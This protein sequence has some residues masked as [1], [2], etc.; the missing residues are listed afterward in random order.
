MPQPASKVIV[1][2]KVGHYIVKEL[3]GKGGMA[4]VYKAYDATLDREIALKVMLPFLTDDFEFEQRFLREARNAAKLDHP[5]I[6]GVYAADRFQSMLYIAMQFVN[7]RSLQKVIFNSKVSVDKA[8]LITFQMAVALESAHNKGIIHRDIKPANIMLDEHGNVKVADFGLS[9]MVR[10]GGSLT[11]AGV[12]L[13]TPEY[14][15]PEQ[16]RGDNLDGRTDIYSLGIV[17]YEMLSGKVPHEAE[18]LLALFDKIVKE[19]PTPINALNPEVLPE[20]T[21]ILDK[22]LAKNPEERYKTATQLKDEL[23]EIIKQRSASTTSTLRK[24]FASSSRKPVA[25]VV[26]LALLLSGAIAFIVFS[27]LKSREPEKPVELAHKD[28]EFYFYRANAYMD[29]G[30][31]RN[32]ISDY[33]KAL[34]MNSTLVDAYLGHA[35]VESKLGEFNDALVDF[36]KALGLKPNYA[37]LFYQR[38]LMKFERNDFIGAVADFNRAIEIKPDYVDAHKAKEEA[39]RKQGGK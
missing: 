13:G 37:E 19:K 35:K 3:V 8:L 27:F 23:F 17:L 1:G 22:M 28:A 38:G 32:A 36:D 7:G 26:L 33:D 10:H 5:N 34:T 9:K 30:D 4:T 20:L 6:V 18:T 21:K 31:F 11:Q 29:K 12:Y 25:L 15:S 16:C 2:E 24:E 39:K 14:S